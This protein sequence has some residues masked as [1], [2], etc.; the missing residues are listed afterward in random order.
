MFA[1]H[2]DAGVCFRREDIDE[3]VWVSVEGDWAGGFE[4]FAVEGWEDADDIVAAR[5]GPNDAGV[6]VDGFEELA[7]D[8]GNG[9]DPFDFLL[10]TAKFSLQTA[11]LV[12]NVLL[13][14]HQLWALRG[15]Q[16][17][18]GLLGGWGIRGPVGVS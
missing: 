9:L 17:R 11:L 5:G 3:G 4:E 16:G 13:Q 7:D 8:E 6:L 14:Q 2:G 1:Q 15:G 18:G 10:G 12:F